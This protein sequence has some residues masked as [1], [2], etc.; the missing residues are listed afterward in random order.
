M[1]HSHETYELEMDLIRHP[2]EP[3][4]KQRLAMVTAYDR[5]EATNSNFDYDQYKSERDAFDRLLAKYVKDR[6]KEKRQARL[7]INRMRE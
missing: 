6:R 5:M 2:P 4:E 3:L 1:P 7:N